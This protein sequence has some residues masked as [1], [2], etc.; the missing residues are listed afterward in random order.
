MQVDINDMP[1]VT[2]DTTKNLQKN[3]FLLLVPS[4]YEKFGDSIKEK[5]DKREWKKMQ[6][7]EQKWEKNNFKLKFRV[8][9]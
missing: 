5:A 2:M 8:E 4:I 9:K 1:I 3:N 6:K 7:C